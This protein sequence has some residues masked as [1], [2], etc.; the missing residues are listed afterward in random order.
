[1]L[2]SK[3]QWIHWYVRQVSCYSPPTN[4]SLLPLTYVLL[5]YRPD[6]L[7]AV[8]QSKDKFTAET[9][10]KKAEL[11]QQLL[12]LLIYTLITHGQCKEYAALR[13][14]SMRV[15]PET[16]NCVHITARGDAVAIV[17]ADHK[18]SKCFGCD[19]ILLSG[20]SPL[21]RHLSQHIQL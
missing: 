5:H 13:L 7:T 1:M 12:A 6:V 2:D 21:L 17:L 18:A 8:Q 16:P 20:D 10:T 11:G 15:N 14:R 3:S 19:H 4:G 9:N